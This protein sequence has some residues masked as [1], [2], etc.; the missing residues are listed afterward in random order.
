MHPKLILYETSD[1]SE[2]ITM[3]IKVLTLVCH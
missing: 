1:L 3:A 2:M